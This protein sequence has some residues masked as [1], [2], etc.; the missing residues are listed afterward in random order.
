MNT[1]RKSRKISFES[2]KMRKSTLEHISE[3]S[4]TQMI[5]TQEILSQNQ[6]SN[7]GLEAPQI[8]ERT[9]SAEL[10][11]AEKMEEENVSINESEICQPLTAPALPAPE[12]VDRLQNLEFANQNLQSRL[13]GLQQS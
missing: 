5:E 3:I 7:R 6:G 10:S 9:R 1:G 4:D 13:S 12:S 8:V 2:R 11:I